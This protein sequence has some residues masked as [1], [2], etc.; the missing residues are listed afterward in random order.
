MAVSDL[1]RLLNVNPVY[2]TRL[3][4]MKTTEPEP[5][6]YGKLETPLSASLVA[7]LDQRG[8]RPYSHQCEA[9][10]HVRAGTNVILTTSTASGK[11]LA[12]NLPVFSQLEAHADSRALY[13]YPTKARTPYSRVP[14]IH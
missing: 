13:L 7:Y 3:V 1:I 4:H 14:E 12:F 11:T 10:N 8:V 2:R 6:R 5:A 9:I